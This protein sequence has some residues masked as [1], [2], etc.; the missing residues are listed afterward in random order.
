MVDGLRKIL[1]PEVALVE[2]V[3]DGRA[4]LKAVARVKPDI[5]IADVSMPRLNGLEATKELRKDY[6][7]IKVIISVE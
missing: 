4:L 2:T 3:E 6:P 1:E 5:A 7:N